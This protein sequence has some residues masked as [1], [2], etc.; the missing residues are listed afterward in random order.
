[1]AGFTVQYNFRL[2]GKTFADAFTEIYL[3]F[4]NILIG[5]ITEKE[6][7]NLESVLS[8]EGN[9]I[10]DFIR[11]KFDEA[12]RSLEIEAKGRMN[13]TINPGKS[14]IIT[15]NDSAIILTNSVSAGRS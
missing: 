5:V 10:D 4:G 11:R 12:G 6:S 15:E 7:F 1:M 14:Y 9:A 13:V 2:R 8:G 3:R